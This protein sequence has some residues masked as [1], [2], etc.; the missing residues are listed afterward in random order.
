KTKGPA[1]IHQ[2]LDLVEKTTRDLYSDDIAHIQVDSLELFKKLKNFLRATIPGASSKLDLYAGDISLFDA[3]GIET[4]IE[5][6]L[7]NRVELPSGGYLIIE[8][9]EALTTI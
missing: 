9:T 6:A 5:K 8:Q 3:Y 4:E 7:S 2:D 1:L